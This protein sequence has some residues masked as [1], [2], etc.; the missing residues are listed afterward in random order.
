MAAFRAAT[1]KGPRPEEEEEETLLTRPGPWAGISPEEFAEHY[2]HNGHTDNVVPESARRTAAHFR[3]LMAADGQEGTVLLSMDGKDYTCRL[4]DLPESYWT[5]REMEATRLT[6]VINGETSAYN[7]R[8]TRA[9]RERRTDSIRRSKCFST[10]DGWGGTNVPTAL[11]CDMP[12]IKLP[13]EHFSQ[14]DIEPT[15]PLPHA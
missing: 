9:S 2:E 7:A 8:L 10:D 1:K 12:G 11:A 14:F 13:K 4:L 3:E 15:P 6:W 5:F